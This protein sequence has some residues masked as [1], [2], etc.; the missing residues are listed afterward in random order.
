MYFVIFENM[1]LY[2]CLIGTLRFTLNLTRS[3]Q[4]N[5][6]SI[7]LSLQWAFKDSIKTIKKNNDKNKLLVLLLSLLLLVLEYIIISIANIIIMV[8]I[9]IAIIII[10]SM[11]LINCTT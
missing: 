10:I 2:I 9:I 5:I 11:S 1:F 6:F 8:L 7:Q 4:D 3:I